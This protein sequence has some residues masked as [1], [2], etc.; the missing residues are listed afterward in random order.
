MQDY[1][2]IRVW[3]LSHA[4]SVAV[5]QVT[6]RFPPDEKFRLIHQLRKAAHSVPTNIVE[7]S[8]RDCAADY[9]HFLNMAWAS[10]REA[11]YHLQSAI[12]YQVCR[13][14]E[15]VALQKQLKDILVQLYNLRMAVLTRAKLPVRPDTRTA[16]QASSTTAQPQLNDRPTKLVASA[17]PRSG[18]DGR[19]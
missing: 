19:R 15:A 2:K 13:R 17:A 16:P 7:G 11:D 5:Y 10:G 6:A 4:F 9:A 8:S 18:R 1:K 14:E 12:D 3:Q